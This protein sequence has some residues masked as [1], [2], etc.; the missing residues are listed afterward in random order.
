VFLDQLQFSHTINLKGRLKEETVT[1]PL[2]ELFLEKMQIAKICEKDLIDS[3]MLL[4]E[5]DFGDTDE[6]HINTKIILGYLTKDW[7]FWKTATD[8]LKTVKDYVDKYPQLKEEDRKVVRS[9]VDFI[10][11]KIDK[12]PKSMKWKMRSKVGTKVKWYQEVDELETD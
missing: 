7:G 10:L 1:M 11:G 9:R 6:E 5:Y 4:R 3:I 2:A 12:A 8:N